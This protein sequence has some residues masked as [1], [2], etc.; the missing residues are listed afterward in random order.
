MCTWKKKNWPFCSILLNKQLLATYCYGCLTFIVKQI[1][2]CYC[3]HH[4]K[5]KSRLLNLCICFPDGTCESLDDWLLSGSYYHFI[6]CLLFSLAA[7]NMRHLIVEACISRN[8]LD[9]SAYFWPGYVSDQINQ[10]PSRIP[11]QVPGWSSFMQGAPLRPVMINSMV[12]A[13]ASRYTRDFFL[14][15]YYNLLW[16]LICLTYSICYLCSFFFYILWYAVNFMHL[17]NVCEWWDRDTKFPK[18]YRASLFG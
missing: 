10:F 2:I 3:Q 14:L 12:S 18:V 13:P 1:Q 16:I 15:L 17:L 4:K 8:L 9:T 5:W 6:I 7:G 11:S